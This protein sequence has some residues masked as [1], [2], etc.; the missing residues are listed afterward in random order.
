MSIHNFLLF[1]LVAVSMTFAACCDN[2]PEFS[3]KGAGP[4]L[5]VDMGILVKSA[6]DARSGL[7]MTS[8]IGKTDKSLAWVIASDGTA[9]VQ[10]DAAAATALE[11]AN[12]LYWAMGN[13]LIT[14]GVGAIVPTSTLTNTST[15]G[16]GT[17]NSGLF[18]YGDFVGMITSSRDL[19]YPIGH[20][21]GTEKDIAR[22][23]LGGSWRLPTAIEWAFLIEEV[24]TTGK[25]DSTFSYADRFWPS[26]FGFLP[27]PLGIEYGSQGSYSG[28]WQSAT[29]RQGYLITSKSTNNSIFLPAV[30]SRRSSNFHGRG[31][32]GGYWSGSQNKVSSFSRY[33]YFDSDGWGV[34]GQHR[35]Y[36][37]AVRPVT[38]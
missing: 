18:G 20:I 16:G 37:F 8:V 27:S 36:G 38:E 30:G 33:F 6:V 29:N 15:Y 9:T 2:E 4:A 24:A 10:T 7:V 12:P 31:S 5:S 14:D 21:S 19:D 25:T 3:Q 1:S 35:Y 11:G 17:W 32:R 26:M 34:E 23:K 22:V 13:L 28:P